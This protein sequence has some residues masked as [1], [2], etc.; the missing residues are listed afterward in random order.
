[1]AFKIA[2]VTRSL[3]DI[4]S[5]IRGMFRQYLPGTDASIQQNFVTVCGKVT[6][7]L[8][9]EYELRLEWIYRQLFMRTATDI[10]ILRMHAADYRIYQK[11]AAP[12]VGLIIGIG[13][14]GVTYPA[15]I[16]YLSGGA[17]FLT[18]AA[19]TAAGDGSFVTSMQAETTGAITNRESE[20]VMTLADPSLYPTLSQQA[21]V[22][23]AG[24]GGGADIEDIESLRA[25]GLERKARPPQGGAL[26]DYERFA[27][28]VPGVLKAWAYQFTNG[29]GSI[30]V[31]FLFS[32]RVNFIPTPGDVAAVQAYI[33]AKR[34]IRVDDAVAIAPLSSAVNITIGDLAT[35]T[36]EVRAAIDD[37]LRALFIDRVRP[38]VAADPFVL[39][40]S[41]ISEAIS[42]A[43]GEDQH[44]LV[45]PATD[46]SFTGG[47]IPVL[48]AVSYA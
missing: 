34:L 23:E 47:H 4:G 19:F 7:L 25:R 2:Y 18:T 8:A 29:I 16:R 21:A 9:R 35:D 40:R 17:S 31:F 37:N 45:L 22:D 15:G 6:A 33:D 44:T 11:P 12:S 38:G 14:A 1:M 10:S 28:E 39:S 5:A 48:G 3:N 20:A 43:T 36:P 32:G 26:P 46:P 24:L 41:W 27:L 42:T 30:A 13:Q